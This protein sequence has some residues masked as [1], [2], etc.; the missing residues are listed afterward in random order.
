MA[1]RALDADE[2]RAVRIVAQGFHRGTAAR[3]RSAGDLEALGHLRTLGGADAYL[4]ARARIPAL[5]RAD[6]EALVHEERLRVVPA[7]RGCIYLV[8]AAHA[9]LCLHVARDL[10]ASRDA[11]D[12]ERAGIRPGELDGVGAAVLQSLRQEGP[13]TTDGLRRRLPKGALR[14]LG[15]RGKKVGVSSTLPPALRQLE[16]GGR[17]AR[18]PL[19]GRL[20]HEK[21]VWRATERDPFAAA[22]LP[23]DPAELHGR[24]LTHFVAHAGVTTLAAFCAWSGLTQRAAKAA[25]PFA[26]STTV[27]AAGLGDEAL[28]S[29]RLDALRR[30]AK[31]HADEAVALLPFA[32][33]LVHLADSLAPFVHED[34]HSLSVPT[35]GKGGK[36]REPL[37]KSRHVLFRSVLAE[38]RIRGFWEY[39]PD[40]GAVE[41]R[42]F[43]QPSKK[44][45]R[46][47]REVAEATS[48]FLRDE[49]GHGRSFSL[50]TDD[51]LRTRT[52]ALRQL[53]TT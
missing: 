32:D 26:R 17:I 11:R 29:P 53:I 48:A 16:F 39:D 28:A 3:R 2:V 41:V 22:D 44:A 43:D 50:D 7:A 10:S 19:E 42:C 31:A 52:A 27:A 25:L 15:E 4:A 35:W 38:G 45:A 37:A 40:A 34:H 24:L 6:L 14:S 13:E 23:E 5:A 49:I 46:A 33:N 9:A 8:P 36:V 20:D 12:A 30:E 1:V 21:Y 51:E 18:L 47:L